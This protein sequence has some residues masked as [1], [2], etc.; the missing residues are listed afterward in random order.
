MKECGGNEISKKV[1]E[2]LTYFLKI[3]EGNKKGEKVKTKIQM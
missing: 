2:N 3:S 1:G